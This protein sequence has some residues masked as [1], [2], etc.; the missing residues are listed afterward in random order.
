MDGSARIE[1]PTDDVARV[2]S[3][4]DELS[5]QLEGLGFA[6]V[7]IDRRGLVSGRLNEEHGVR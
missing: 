4:H 3:S 6:R 7:I 2:E 1:V 5:R